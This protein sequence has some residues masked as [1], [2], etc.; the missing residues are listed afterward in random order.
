MGAAIV[1]PLAEALGKEL[2]PL[3]ITEIQK[4]MAAHGAA[5]DSA[6]TDE[7]IQAAAQAIR[8]RFPLAAKVV[9]AALQPVA[10]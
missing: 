7:Q 1:L 2:L 8:D 10:S 6:A 9:G 3:V 5:A 4:A